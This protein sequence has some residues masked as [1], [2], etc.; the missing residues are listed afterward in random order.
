MNVPR[1]I[2]SNIWIAVTGYSGIRPRFTMFFLKKRFGGC[3]HSFYLFDLFQSHTFI[4]T[5]IQYN[6]FVHLHSPR[7]LSISSLLVAQRKTSLECR[8]R[9]LN[10]G[11]P[12]IRPAHYQLSYAAPCAPQC[13]TTA[14]ACGIKY[15]NDFTYF[16]KRG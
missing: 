13:C 9:D 15:T 4:I 16:Q 5:F 8:S 6:T 12:Y 14:I 7:P 10:S 2:M 1:N 11:L 3:S